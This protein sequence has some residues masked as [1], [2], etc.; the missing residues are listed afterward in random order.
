MIVEEPKSRQPVGLGFHLFDQGQRG[1]FT[2]R[3]VH[4]EQ[5]GGFL[6]AD[7]VGVKRLPVAVQIF[8]TVQAGFQK[9]RARAHFRED[10]ERGK[11]HLFHHGGAL[12]ALISGLARD[13]REIAH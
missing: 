6:M 2:L 1:R 12:R 10:Y 8:E 5:L 13:H 11:R 3:E 9:I 7:E 4:A